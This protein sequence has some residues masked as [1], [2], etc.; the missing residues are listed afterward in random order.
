M[1][2][3]FTAALADFVAEN[4]AAEYLALAEL[5]TLKTRF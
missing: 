1:Q 3:R 5:G 4:T 2:K